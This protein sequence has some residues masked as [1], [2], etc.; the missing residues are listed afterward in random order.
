M[1]NGHAYKYIVKIHAARMAN[2][3]TERKGTTN[4]NERKM[5]NS[6]RHCRYFRLCCRLDSR[7]KCQIKHT[8]N[9]KSKHSNRQQ[10]GI[11]CICIYLYI[12]SH[13]KLLIT[14]FDFC[15]ISFHFLLLL[16]MFQSA[17]VPKPILLSLCNYANIL[18]YKNIAQLDNLRIC[19]LCGMHK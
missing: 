10:L 6:S 16:F 2:L 14:H 9:K 7:H 18:N 1:H 19:I 11:C 4:R 3:N 13:W 15:F 12:S 17:S 8:R 5:G